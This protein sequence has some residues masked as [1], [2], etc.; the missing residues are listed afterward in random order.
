M[1]PR[2]LLSATVLNTGE[3]LSAPT[4]QG[5][6]QTMIVPHVSSSTDEKHTLVS[7]W[8]LVVASTGKSG[9]FDS[10]GNFCIV[11]TTKVYSKY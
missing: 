2:S 4:M 5:G 11:F 8:H 3:H 9:S 7:A 10:F 1:T 6:L